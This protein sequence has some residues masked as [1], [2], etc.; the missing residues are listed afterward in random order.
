VIAVVGLGHDVRQIGE[1][2][3]VR[4]RE[5]ARLGLDGICGPGRSERDPAIRRKR[6]EVAAGRRCGAEPGEKHRAEMVASRENT[7]ALLHA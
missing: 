3:G 7:G 2:A 1:R 6:V 4:I 5:D